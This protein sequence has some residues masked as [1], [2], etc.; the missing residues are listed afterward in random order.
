MFFDLVHDYM[1]IY[2]DYFTTYGDAFDEALANFG[3]YVNWVHKVK[4]FP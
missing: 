1:E 4:C 2:M 3:K